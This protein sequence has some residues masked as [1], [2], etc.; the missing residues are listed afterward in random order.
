MV[1]E[2][3]FY[4]AVLTSLRKIVKAQGLEPI[5]TGWIVTMLTKRLVITTLISVQV[6]R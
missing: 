2:E 1:I 4:N 5:I 6:T 3:A